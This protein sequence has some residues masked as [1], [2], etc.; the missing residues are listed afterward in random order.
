VRGEPVAAVG[1]FPVRQRGPP[2][3]GVVGWPR[4]RV[5]GRVPTRGLIMGEP[6]RRHRGTALLWCGCARTC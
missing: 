6:A 1:A 3:V 4:R 5:R 2:L